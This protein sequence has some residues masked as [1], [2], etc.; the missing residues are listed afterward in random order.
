MTGQVTRLH[1]VVGC[2]YISV[3]LAGD[4]SL[5]RSRWRRR[6]RYHRSGGSSSPAPL[7]LLSCPLP[8]RRTWGELLKG[9]LAAYFLLRWRRRGRRW[10]RDGS[11]WEDGGHSLNEPLVRVRVRLRLRLRLRLRVRARAR[12]RARVRLA[13]P[14]R[15]DPVLRLALTPNPGPH[16]DPRPHPHLHPSR[17]PRSRASCRASARAWCPSRCR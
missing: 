15:S 17:R 12:A 3:Y 2:R 4:I 5:W 10:R 1:L 16:P 11:R 13:A 9:W 8:L 7:L 14:W 6:S